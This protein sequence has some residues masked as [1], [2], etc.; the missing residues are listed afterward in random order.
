MT[1]GLKTLIVNS[2][3]VLRKKIGAVFLQPLFYKCITLLNIF[4][5][6]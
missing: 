5:T 4:T 1:N 6:E 3:F 2:P